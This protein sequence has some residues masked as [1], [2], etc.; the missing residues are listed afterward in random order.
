MKTPC[1]RSRRNVCRPMFSAPARRLLRSALLCCLAIPCGLRAASDPSLLPEGRQREEL[2]PSERNPFTQQVA[3]ETPAPTNVQDGTTEE[4]R[5]RRIFRATKVG[6]ISGKPGARHALLGSL[7]LKPG[8][9]LPPILKDQFEVL[10]VV[11]VDDASIV[12]AFVER[13][14]SLDARQIVL[15]VGI[16]P[17]VSRV[18]I[19]ETFEELT[20]MGPSG[21]IEAPPVTNKGVEDLLKGSREADLRNIAD[22]D[23]QMMGVVTNEENADKK[24]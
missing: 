11:S 13:D 21:K 24:K 12:I 2:R 15:P 22:R 16:K 8:D 23:V 3:L 17:E 20:K 6:G 9:T 7:I 14:S 18:M 19:G 5:L 1:H 4:A 10:R